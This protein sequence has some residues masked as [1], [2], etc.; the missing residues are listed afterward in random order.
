M[1]ARPTG[2]PD[3]IVDAFDLGTPTASAGD[4]GAHP[5]LSLRG[6]RPSSRALRASRRNDRGVGSPK[7][8]RGVEG[9]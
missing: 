2:R 8:G 1:L 4:A 9:V 5:T 3:T 6:R 7:T